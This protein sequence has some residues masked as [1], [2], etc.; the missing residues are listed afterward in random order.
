[1]RTGLWW[2]NKDFKGFKVIKGFKDDKGFK[3][4]RGSRYDIA[5]YMDKG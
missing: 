2:R 5:T 4:G 1:M 3:D